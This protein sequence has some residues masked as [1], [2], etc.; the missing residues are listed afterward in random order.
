MGTVTGVIRDTQGNAIA[1]AVV[2]LRYSKAVVGY[3]GD[4]VASNL[5]VFT[6]NGSG[7]VTMADLVPGVY[8]V[9]ISVPST[10]QAVLPVELRNTSGVVVSSDPQSLQS[11]LNSDPGIITPSIL[12]QAEAEA[13][14]AAAS[15][16]EAALYDGPW[17]NNVSALL[18]DTSLTYTAGQPGTV[19]ENDIVRTR[20]E[21]FAYE[22]AA[23]GATDHHVTTAGGV[24]LYVLPIQGQLAREA[25][26]SGTSAINA[27]ADA[28]RATGT[29][30]S[31][32]GGTYQITATIDLTN[33]K[34]TTNGLVTLLPQFNGIAVKWN[35][36]DT[37]RIERQS[38][39]GDGIRVVWPDVNRTI[40]R[41]AFD[42]TNSDFGKFVI[43]WAQVNRGLLLQSNGGVS[44]AGCTH[45]FID[46]RE[47]QGHIVGIHTVSLSAAGWVN[48]NYI[49]FGKLYG[50]GVASSSLYGAAI[51]HIWEADTPYQNN[52]NSYEG[53]LE[54]DNTEG[55]RLATLL[56]LRSRL[57][58]TYAEYD[59][60]DDWI[61]VG[62]SENQLDVSACPYIVGHDV[63]AVNRVNITGATA[64]QIIG[65]QGYWDLN[66]VGTQRLRQNS[67]TRAAI[68]AENIFGTGPAIFIPQGDISAEGNT[69]IQGQFLPEIRGSTVAGT[70]TYVGRRGDYTIF[71]NRVFFTARV[72]WSGL[73]GASGELIIAGLPK[74]VVSDEYARAPVS[75]VNFAV[76][77]SAGTTLTGIVSNGASSITLLEATPASG[78]VAL[79]AIDTA[80]DLYVSGSYVW[81]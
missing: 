3:E 62:G 59:V 48:G 28:M 46:I 29:P 41:T 34:V 13:A 23:S 51:G 31:W 9:T 19:A 39:L 24:K 50:G 32:E 17:L 54:Y 26:G 27:W 7:E 69:Q 52:G 8:N 38:L 14:A 22:V 5:R 61:F 25:F 71:G 15:A 74:P 79:V 43:S 70:A 67:P 47:G 11:F 77:T 33:T 40:D 35:P 44:G 6:A 73:S 68:T 4:A 65:P 30:G 16:A 81:R 10:S 36:G 60:S 58:V 21:G 2:T 53:A 1:G 55:F 20:A 45:N 76:A 18:A 37:T 42:I 66:G 49:K 80:G 72:N 75:V 78:A 57:R 64:P 63:G 12:Q 56:G